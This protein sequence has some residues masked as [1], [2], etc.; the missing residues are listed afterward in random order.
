[1]VIWD[2]QRLQ[3]CLCRHGCFQLMM[4]ILPSAASL[5]TSWLMTCV[6]IHNGM[7]GCHKAHAAAACRVRQSSTELTQICFTSSSDALRL[8]GH[9]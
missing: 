7:P 1:M 6:D 5:Y 3:R 2:Q 4:S 9:Y 8:C